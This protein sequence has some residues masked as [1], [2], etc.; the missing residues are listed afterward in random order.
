M[1]KD[2]LMIRQIDVKPSDEDMVI[3]GYAA[4]YDS[5]TVLWTDEDGTQYK[6]VIER[7]AFSAADLSNVVLRY[8]HSPAWTTD[9]DDPRTGGNVLRGKA[10]WYRQQFKA[11]MRP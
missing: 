3:E 1:N 2:Q 8:N 4:V 5:P 10:N 6:E 9:Y 7:G 11:R